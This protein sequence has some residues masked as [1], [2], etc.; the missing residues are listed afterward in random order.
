MMN[1]ANGTVPGIPLNINK[2]GHWKIL[3][4]SVMKKKTS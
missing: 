1:Y 4:D 3:G 2:T